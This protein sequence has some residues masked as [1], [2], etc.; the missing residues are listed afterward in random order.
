[1]ATL[2]TVLSPACP[3]LSLSL[4]LSLSVSCSFSA[5]P[6]RAETWGNSSLVIHDLAGTR[7]GCAPLGPARPP[8][9]TLMC[10][11]GASYSL[12]EYEVFTL[13]ELRSGAV[14]LHI[15]GIAYVFYGIGRVCDL[16]FMPT[17]EAIVETLGA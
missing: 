15:I 6:V 2:T 5:C 11:Q 12:S 17:L 7:I 13:D 16:H 1:M 10:G 3:I 8:T 14:I 4:S 9:P